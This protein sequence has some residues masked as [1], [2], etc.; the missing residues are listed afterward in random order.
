MKVRK[1]MNICEESI[2]FHRKNGGKLDIN[3]KFNIASK[4]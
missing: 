4:A 2:E 1:T 3:P